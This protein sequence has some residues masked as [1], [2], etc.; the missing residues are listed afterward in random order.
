M[1]RALTL[2]SY[3]ALPVMDAHTA[4]A[5]VLRLLAQYKLHKPALRNTKVAAA[6]AALGKHGDALAAALAAERSNKSAAKAAAELD[7]IV[8][9]TWAA[10][11]LTLEGRAKATR[12]PSAAQAKAILDRVFPDRLEFTQE[13]YVRQWSIANATLQKL[14]SADPSDP[15]AESA[16]D[17]LREHGAGD[18]L[19]ELR[20]A[21]DE[22]AALIGVTEG[23][24]APVPVAVR[25]PLDAALD[26]ARE[27][28]ATVL[29]LSES[30]VRGDVDT[31][32]RDLL[33]VLD[34]F[35]ADRAEKE[36][37]APPTPAT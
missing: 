31:I 29:A 23:R 17:F 30:D 18:L 7:P 26:S 4:D 11:V 10:I 36:G 9:A 35:T 21:H 1:A 27:L 14:M 12:L 2:A 15:K 6:A 3:I 32:K 8:D 34:E 20:K 33:S 16:A 25:A 19:D 5:F 13:K 22:F 28:V 37:S 24:S